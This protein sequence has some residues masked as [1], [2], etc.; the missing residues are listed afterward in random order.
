[1]DKAQAY[2][3]FWNG[4]NVPA[5]DSA[6]VPDTATFP[7]ITYTAATDNYEHTLLLTADLWYRESTWENATQKVEEIGQYIENMSPMPCDGGYLYITRGNPFA[8]RMEDPDDDKIRRYYININVS[9]L[10]RY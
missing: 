10:T 3:A 2:N 1:M 4:F 6:S 8:Q 5:Y 9:F 7:R